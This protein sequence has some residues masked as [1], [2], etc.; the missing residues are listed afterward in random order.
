MQ[1]GW[2]ALG[3]AWLVGACTTPPPRVP[4]DTTEGFHA[5]GV[6]AS[7]AT[8][9]RYHSSYNTYGVE[10]FTDAPGTN[11]WGWEL[12]LRYGNNT[13]DDF[14][15]IRIVAPPNGAQTI[16]V[17]TKRES[18]FFEFSVGTRQTFW[19][20]ARL[21]PYI[22]VGG[23]L[24]KIKNVD[25]LDLSGLPPLNPNVQAPRS[26]EHWEALG[27]GIYAHTGL[28]W[29]VLRDQFHENTEA[30]VVFDVR[31]LLGEEYSFIE[32]SLGIGFGR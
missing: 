7:R 17:P 26:E 4:F 3:I 20:G 24:T 13:G 2:L 10:V 8:S 6:A 32:A 9:D 27:V 11:G 16:A 19:K 5:M 21:Q 1:R 22:G 30:V 15:R 23:V 12:G 31:G 25:Q 28:R 14:E 18:D 29:N